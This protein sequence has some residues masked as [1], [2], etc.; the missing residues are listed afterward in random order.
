[1]NRAKPISVYHGFNIYKISDSQ[2]IAKSKDKTLYANTE[3]G[4]FSE[5]YLHTV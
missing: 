2:Y 1:M 5:V 3:H 4:I